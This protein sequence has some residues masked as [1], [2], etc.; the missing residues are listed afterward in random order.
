M[1]KIRIPKKLDVRII[2][3]ANSASFIKNKIE[4]PRELP[5]ILRSTSGS[6]VISINECSTTYAL[7]VAV[8]DDECDIIV[9]SFQVCF[10]FFVTGAQKYI[11]YKVYLKFK[12][13]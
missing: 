13:M 5:K 1:P 2:K 10:I 9:V 12:L 8:A 3:P 11:F 7:N 4:L 6:K